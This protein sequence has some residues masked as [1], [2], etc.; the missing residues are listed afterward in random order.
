M[1]ALPR[2]DRSKATMPRPD[3]KANPDNSD[4]TNGM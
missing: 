3:S 1:V 4:S 2:I